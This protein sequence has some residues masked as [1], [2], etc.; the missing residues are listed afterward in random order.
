ML[1][2][3]QAVILAAGKSSRF[4]TGKT[5]LVEKI[6]GQE[7]ILYPT[8]LL[9]NLKLP[10][11]LVVGFQRE[12]IEKTVMKQF[13]DDVT[14]VHQT[15]Q[16]GTGHAI[17]CSQSTWN[18]DHILIM[19][20]DMPLINKDLIQKLY[21]KHV[22]NN[23]SISF[24]TAH[25]C[26]PSAAS[27]GR[28]IKAADSIEIIEAKEFKEDL[29]EHCCINAGI[30]IAKRTF[31]ETNIPKLQQSSVAKE[32]YITDLVKL[33]SDQKLGVETI[34][35][36]FDCI[37]GI[38]TFKELWA[39]EQIKK[40]EIIQKWMEQGVRFAIAHNVQIDLNVMIGAGT[41]ID[42]GVHLL[43]TT[44]IGKN[45]SVGAFSI[46][47]NSTI[48]DSALVHSHSIITNATLEAFSS[49]GPFAHIHEKSLIQEKATIGNFVEIK[50]SVVGQET[51]AKHL[52]YIGDAKIGRRVNIGAGTITCNYNGTDKF[53]TTIEDDVFVGSNAT[54]IAPLTIKKHAFIAAGSTITKDVPEDAL[55]IARERQTNKENYARNLRKSKTAGNNTSKDATDDKESALPFLAAFKVETFEPDHSL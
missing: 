44:K 45:C 37:R 15:D 24:V 33:A 12:L 36:P 52:A 30:Y 39:A 43:G 5:K 34:S 8:S 21:T 16:L 28:V 26:D 13:S 23:A 53:K 40:S 6:C 14:F 3:V 10:V 46:L 42:S 7:M 50:K 47:K 32:W 55:A 35:A 22:H 41:F 25:N 31:L 18:R 49:V 4:K 20:G 29:S 1:K 11:T 27:Y 17:A 9:I 38:N 48:S 2:N 51:K 19:N 54:L